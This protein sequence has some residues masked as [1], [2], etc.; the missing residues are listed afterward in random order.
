[1]RG[2]RL[3]LLV[4]LLVLGGIALSGC[5]Q[6]TTTP[7]NASPGTLRATAAWTDAEHLTID[8]RNVGGSNYPMAGEG[9]MNLT[10]PNG[11]M[12]IHWNGAAPTLAP[13]QSVQFELHAMMMPDGTMG[14][15]MDHAHGEHMP[16][17]MGDY[18]LRIGDATAHAMLGG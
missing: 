6:S 10:G 5:I 15:T 13:G 2:T 17:P 3:A 1:M 11:T 16:M 18:M 14:M 9:M 8:V 4:G 12:P 7:S